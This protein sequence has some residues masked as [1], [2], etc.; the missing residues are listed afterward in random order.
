MRTVRPVPVLLAFAAGLHLAAMP[1]HLE[2]S[3]AAGAFFL[4][5]AAL[6]LLGAA[7][8]HRGAT[9]RTRAFV[10]VVNLGVIAVWAVSRTIGTEPVG[11][12]DGLA[13]GAGLCAVVALS[14]PTAPARRTTGLAGLPALALVALVMTGI[15][16]RLV[17]AAHAHGGRAATAV[18]PQHDDAH[19]DH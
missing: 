8:V 9:A 10:V 15:G 7:L 1:S 14:L 4:V 13:I 17:P 6:Q 3:V 5:V 16:L 19:H 18:V 12:I 11:L 2:E